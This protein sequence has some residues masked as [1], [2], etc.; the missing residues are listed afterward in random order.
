MDVE[1]RETID[2]AIDRARGVANEAIDRIKGELVQ[3]LLDELQ[4]WRAV[5]ERLNLGRKEEK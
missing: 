3:P 5:A 1:S 4:R 2:E